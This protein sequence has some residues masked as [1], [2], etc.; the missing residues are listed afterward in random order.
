MRAAYKSKHYS[1]RSKANK[2]CGRIV[3]ATSFA[4]TTIIAALFYMY[5]NEIGVMTSAKKTDL[6]DT[7]SDE[8]K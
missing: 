4:F 2:K 1:N 8:I 3:Y 7:Q 6:S 5:V